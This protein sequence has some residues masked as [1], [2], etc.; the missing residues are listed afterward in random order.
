MNSLIKTISQN[1]VRTSTLQCGV[2][3][4]VPSDL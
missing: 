4:G 2:G 3:L 1:Y